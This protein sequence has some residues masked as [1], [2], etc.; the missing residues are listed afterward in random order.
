MR[1]RDS[2]HQAKLTE[3]KAKLKLHETIEGQQETQLLKGEEERLAIQRRF[4]ERV[5]QAER[6]ASEEGTRPAWAVAQAQHSSNEAVRWQQELLDERTKLQETD[7][8]SREIVEQLTARAQ[9]AEGRAA[10][11]EAAAD[12]AATDASRLKAEC[13]ARARARTLH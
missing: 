4:A 9:H 5:E 12:A 10:A 11:A 6:K 7:T 1:A 13:S 3:M 2:A 8:R